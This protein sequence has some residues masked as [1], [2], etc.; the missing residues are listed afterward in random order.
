MISQGKYEEIL[1]NGFR[2]DIVYGSNLDE[3]EVYD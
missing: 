3:E 2:S 1:L